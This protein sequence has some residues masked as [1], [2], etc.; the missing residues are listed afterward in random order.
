MSTATAFI[1]SCVQTA[2]GKAA[3]V[4]RGSRGRPHARK[5][6]QVLADKKNIL[7]TTHQHP[8]PDALGSSLALCQLLSLKLKDAKV[9]MSIKGRIGGGVN[10][11]FTRH[12]PLSLVPWDDHTLEDYDAI[13]LLDVQPMFAYSPLPP[14]ISPIAVIDH[15]PAPGRKLKFPFSDIRTDVG[16][17]CSIIFSYFMELETEI[18]PDLA[19]TMLYAI[20]TDLAG[21][22]GMPGSLDNL[23][24]SSL[25]LVAN[26]EKLYLMRYVDLPQSYYNAYF[27]GLSNAVI[28]DNA[29]MSF[30]GEI[31]SLEQPAIIA[32]FLMRHDK[33]QWALVTAVNNGKL[34]FSLRTSDLKRSAG[35]IARRLIRNIGEGGGHRAK[36]GGY[37]KLENGSPT[38]IDR[39][40]QLLRTRLLRALKIKSTRGQK[41]VGG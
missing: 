6:L 19:A 40:R 37:V 10:D 7:V 12:T 13:V 5:L 9:S 21:A 22:V 29:V 2:K 28:H 27:S 36:A 41:L 33:V 17:T 25:T 15:H 24:V 23:A 35:Q 39:V 1:A 26:M 16:A 4:Q 38:E 14:D 18:P 34:I 32:D 11:A 20:E 3:V 31:D 8:D 30:I